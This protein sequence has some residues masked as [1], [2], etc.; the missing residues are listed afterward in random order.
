MKARKSKGGARK[1]PSPAK[2]RSP[3]ERAYSLWLAASATVDIVSGDKEMTAALDDLRRAEW[4]VI[5]TPA[6]QL[7]QIQKR[8]AFTQTLIG[9]TLVSGNPLDNRDQAA[10]AVLVAEI[11]RFAP[12][13]P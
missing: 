4:Q 1:R 11:Q 13:T 8:A 9:E 3:F 2:A 6:E 7:C 10:L 12:P 5:R